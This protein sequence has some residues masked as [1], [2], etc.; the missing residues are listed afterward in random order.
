MW[1]IR[2]IYGK[3]CC[4]RQT[5][6]PCLLKLP[7]AMGAI[8]ALVGWVSAGDIL[9]KVDVREHPPNAAAPVHGRELWQAIAQDLRQSPAVGTPQTFIAVLLLSQRLAKHHTPPP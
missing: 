2:E 5:N 6:R 7:P 8:E 1:P 4:S 3:Q 9:Y